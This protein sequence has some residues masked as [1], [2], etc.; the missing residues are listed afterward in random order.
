MKI[1]IWDND[2]TG[3]PEFIQGSAGEL[4]MIDGQQVATIHQDE[5]G[6]FHYNSSFSN[7]IGSTRQDCIAE[8]LRGDGY[9]VYK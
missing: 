5:Q 6:Q 9:T 8:G 2:W 4:V 3:E 7:L 1:G